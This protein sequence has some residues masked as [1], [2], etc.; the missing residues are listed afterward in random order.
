MMFVDA[1]AFIARAFRK[2]G[3]FATACTGFQRLA[4]DGT[5]LLTTGLVIAEVLNYTRKR[6]P[7]FFTVQVADGIFQFPRLTIHRP[8]LD[9]ESAAMRLMQEYADQ[10]FSFTDCVSFAVMRKLGLKKAFTFD[11]DFSV[12]G[13][14]IWP[15]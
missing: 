1:N 12:A 3:D 15:S 4:R 2:D 8:E 10:D 6:S 13:F 5:P 9:D 7:V 14:E 11:R